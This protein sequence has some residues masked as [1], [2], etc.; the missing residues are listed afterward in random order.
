M[1]QKAA[2]CPNQEREGEGEEMCGKKE[3]AGVRE[4]KERW[5]FERIK[6]KE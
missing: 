3:G 2:L 1:P 6:G 4:Q 5:R